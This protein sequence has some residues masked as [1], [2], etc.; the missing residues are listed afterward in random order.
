MYT[1]NRAEQLIKGVT[2]M[3]IIR[4]FQLPIVRALMSHNTKHTHLAELEG[5]MEWSRETCD[6]LTGFIVAVALVRPDH[7][8]PSA[9][10]QIRQHQRIALT[11]PIVVRVPVVLILKREDDDCIPMSRRRCPLTNS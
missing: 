5:L 9:A 10:E 2:M 4:S 3:V 11:N 8:Q 7:S 6:E 1:G